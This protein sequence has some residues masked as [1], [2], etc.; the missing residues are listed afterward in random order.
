MLFDS[1]SAG[2]GKRRMAGI[3]CR[4]RIT[5]FPGVVPVR[6]VSGKIQ[7][8]L[9]CLQLG[10][11]QAEE[12]GVQGRE[13]VGKPLLHY[14]S[15]AVHVPAYKFHGQVINITG[16]FQRASGSKAGGEDKTG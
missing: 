9:A 16:Q 15:Q 5:L 6:T 8:D 11:L 7:F 14:G 13:Y 3:D 4:S 2:D 12:I 10:F 1:N